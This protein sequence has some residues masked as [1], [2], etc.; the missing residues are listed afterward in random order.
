MKYTILALLILN[1]HLAQAQTVSGKVIS[2]FGRPEAIYD[3]ENEF[4]EAED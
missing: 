4:E 2:L 3:D 1:I